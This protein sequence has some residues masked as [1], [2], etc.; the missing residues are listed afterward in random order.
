M[1]NEIWKDIF[2]YEGLY[3]ISTLGNVKRLTRE[4]YNRGSKRTTI[5]P[6]L[7]M[8]KKITHQGYEEITLYK[9]KKTKGWSIHRLVAITFIENPNSLECVNHINSNRQDNRKENLEWLSRLDNVRHGNKN[10]VKTKIK[11]KLTAKQLANGKRLGKE[12]IQ[13]TTDMEKIK[14]FFSITDA[15]LNTGICQ[16]TIRKCVNGFTKSAGGFIWKYVDDTNVSKINTQTVRLILR[17]I[18]K[19]YPDNYNEYISNLIK[20]IQAE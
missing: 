20:E 6:E 17:R 5:L 12:I 10:K 9:D 7:I 14:S 13:Y 3:Q 15:S 16:S 18:L 4:Y 2:G 19:H 1:T 11:R 8:K